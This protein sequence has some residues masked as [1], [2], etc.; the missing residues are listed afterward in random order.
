MTPLQYSCKQRFPTCRLSCPG[1]P[2][3]AF[4]LLFNLYFEISPDIQKYSKNSPEF[5]GTLHPTSSN[6]NTL[7]DH[8]TLIN[9][10]KINTDIMLLHYHRPYSRFTHCSTSIVFSGPGFNPESRVTFSCHACLLS[11][12]L[13]SGPVLLSF[14]AFRNLDIFEVHWPVLVQHLS[15]FGFV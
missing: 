15:Q 10:R 1:N 11:T 2:Y 8:S 9:I 6:V 14:S 7:H 13:Q 12:H 4:I 3:P 5:T